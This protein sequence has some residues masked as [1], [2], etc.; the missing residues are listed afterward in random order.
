[1]KVKSKQL[2][3]LGAGKMDEHTSEGEDVF[4]RITNNFH[5]V[6]SHPVH[7]GNVGSAARAMK[8]FGF[9]KLVLISCKDPRKVPEASWLAHGAQDV[10]ETACLCSSLDEAL[11]PME[12]VIGT[13]SRRGNRWRDV[14]DPQELGNLLASSWDGRPLALLFGPEDRGLSVEELSRCQWVVRMPTHREC[15]SMNLSHAVAILCYVIASRT[16]RNQEGDSRR[17]PTPE[18]VSRFFEHVQGILKKAA[19]LTG[20]PSRD[21]AVVRRLQRLLLR[22]TPGKTEF[23]LLWALLRHTEKRFPGD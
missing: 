16:F 22:S 7:P 10:L 9:R 11:A 14:L 13:T 1:M 23:K 20:D 19:F 3:T 5:I 8:N 17:S 6:L 12:I 15:P 4:H 21:A 2:R 18:D